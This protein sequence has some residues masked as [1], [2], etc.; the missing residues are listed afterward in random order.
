M[1]PHNLLLA[2]LLGMPCL[3]I[4][5]L[6]RPDPGSNMHWCAPMCTIGEAIQAD[7]VVADIPP[8]VRCEL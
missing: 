5:L 4:C 8:L 1:H 7:K 6:W 3:I 2:F